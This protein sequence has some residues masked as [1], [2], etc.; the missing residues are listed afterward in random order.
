MKG[1]GQRLRGK[2]P[3]KSCWL[4]A[5]PKAGFAEAMPEKMMFPPHSPAVW[6][7]MVQFAAPVREEVIESLN[8][9]RMQRLGVFMRLETFI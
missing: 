3:V 1:L 7:E 5:Q 9:Q 8:R 6:N 4:Y 2:V